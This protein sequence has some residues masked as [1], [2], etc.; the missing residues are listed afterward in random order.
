MNS[1]VLATYLVM[2]L[3]VLGGSASADDTARDVLEKV[4]NTYET[5]TDVELKFT[6]RVRMSVGRLDQSVT[7]AL[8]MKKV[9]KYRIEF[10]QQIIVTDGETVWSYSVSQQQVL[11]DRFKMDERSLTPDRIL[12]GEAGNLTAV[13]LGKDKIGKHETVVLK[14]TPTE[15]SSL[16]KTL[17]LWVSE[18]DWLVRKAELLDLNG[19][20]TSYTVTEIR[21]NTGL[22]DTRFTF[23]PPAGVEIIDL[24]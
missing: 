10:E 5:I 20:E 15:E 3:L 21:L 18:S 8:L 4:R 6:Q 7:G 11:V 13:L 22:P 12:R 1:V 14:L 19:K 17:K 16:V 23:T 2:S 24:R 9:N